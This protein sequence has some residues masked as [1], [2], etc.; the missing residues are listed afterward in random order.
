M[1]IIE[2]E[3]VTSQGDLVKV[4]KKY[5][6]VPM[7]IQPT[8]VLSRLCEML[9]KDNPDNKYAVMSNMF[10]GVVVSYDDITEIENALYNFKMTVNPDGSG[11]VLKIR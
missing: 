7:L 8:M 1:T 4:C 6:L 2:I 5:G 3:C 9:Y 11:M 10:T